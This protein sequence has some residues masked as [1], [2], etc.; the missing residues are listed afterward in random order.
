MYKYIFYRIYDLLRITGNY[1]VAFGASNLLSFLWSILTGILIFNFY[2]NPDKSFVV[3]S[4]LLVYVISQIIHHVYFLKNNNYQ[5]VLQKFETE[6][7][8]TRNF[9]RFFTLLIILLILYCTF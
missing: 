7:S 5:F 9:A 6:K 3:S 8:R 4:L 1:E 2:E